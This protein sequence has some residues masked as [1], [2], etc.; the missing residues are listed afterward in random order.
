MTMTKHL[1]TIIMMGALSLSNSLRAAY[2]PSLL[3]ETISNCDKLAREIADQIPQHGPQIGELSGAMTSARSAI[4]KGQHYEPVNI[5]FS[6]EN[7]NLNEEFTVLQKNLCVGAALMQTTCLREKA[8]DRMLILSAPRRQQR[9]YPWEPLE[10]VCAR[11]IK[12]EL[13]TAQWI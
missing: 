2:D 12:C 3:L 13:N 11:T 6:P 8:M 1:T 9:R 5:V 7:P 4:A 10:A